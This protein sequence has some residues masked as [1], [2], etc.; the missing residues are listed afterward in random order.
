MEGCA[1]DR[2]ECSALVIAI[3]YNAF[4]KNAH[5]FLSKRNLAATFW[6]QE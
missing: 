3:D 4:V 5:G 6:I 2:Q 1:K